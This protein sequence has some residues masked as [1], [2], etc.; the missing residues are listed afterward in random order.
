MPSP[1]TAQLTAARAQASSHRAVRDALLAIAVVVCGGLLFIQLDTAERV[2]SA[3]RHWERIELDDLLLTSFLAVIVTSW[4]AVRRW[5]EASIELRARQA[6]E[7]DKA[8]YVQRLEELSE[9]LLET[10]QR[11]RTRL[12]ELLHDDIG[13]TLYACRLQ[14]ER[15]RTRVDDPDVQVLL[16][17]AH[18]LAG[19][20]MTQTREL[21]VD[22]SPPVLHDLGLAEA[23]AWLLRRTEERFGLQS[24][25]V[26]GDSWERIPAAWHAAVFHSLSELVANT[27]KHAQAQHLEI[28]ADLDG[29]GCLRVCV[30]DDGRGFATAGPS[31]K[32]F[33]LFSIERRMAW[34]GAELQVESSSE[35][36]TRAT[37]HLP[38][39]N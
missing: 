21:T 15:V 28:S 14:L 29:D 31:A 19:A 39:A 7:Q 10:E 35:S 11:Q 25:L 5:R 9:Q 38:A 34:L 2:S 4:F 36:G 3:L 33:G 22:L 27:A 6:S 13:Q 8:R 26:P 20:A 1:S 18:A 17:E 24:R 12:A 32:G 37:L 30:R 16:D 23:V